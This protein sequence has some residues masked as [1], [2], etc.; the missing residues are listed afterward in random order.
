MAE[1][2]LAGAVQDTDSWALPG[3]SV[4]AAG[5]AGRP[6]FSVAAGDQGPS[7]WVLAARTC[8]WYEVPLVNG[9][10]VAVVVVLVSAAFHSVQALPPSEE[11]RTS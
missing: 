8:T 10:M 6:A 5:A 4:G 9:V 2:W 3:V 1:P 7:P 11:Y